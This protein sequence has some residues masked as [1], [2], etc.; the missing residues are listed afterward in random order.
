MRHDAALLIV[1][2][3]GDPRT[4][5]K[6]SSE[7]HRLLPSSELL[8]LKGANRHGLHGQYGNACDAMRPVKRRALEGEPPRPARPGRV[9]A[10]WLPRSGEASS[11]NRRSASATAVRYDSTLR[12]LIDS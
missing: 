12:S 6:S 5:C 3:T 8:T 10:H 2:A 4:M 7:L 9:T 11:S 1:A